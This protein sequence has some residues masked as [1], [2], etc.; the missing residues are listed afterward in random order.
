VSLV[1][2]N[3]FQKPEEWT[4]PGLLLGSNLLADS[5]VQALDQFD[6]DQC[7]QVGFLKRRGI[8][9]HLKSD[10]HPATALLDVVGPAVRELFDFQILEALIERG[11]QDS[12]FWPLTR[13]WAGGMDA[14]KRLHSGMIIHLSEDTNGFSLSPHVDHKEVIAWMQVYLSPETSKTGT[15]FHEH[16]DWSI[17]KQVPF[18]R[19]SGYFVVNTDRAVHSVVNDQDIKRRSLI[20][21]WTL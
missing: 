7:T 1:N 13:F 16:N 15:I 14:I 4:C 17:E 20:I 18:V 5:L 8:T 19:N 11:F 12:G 6:Y 10:T 3:N 9:A 2:V 21:G